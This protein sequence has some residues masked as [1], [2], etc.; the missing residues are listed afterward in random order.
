MVDTD[1]LQEAYLS[2]TCIDE[3]NSEIVDDLP[4]ADEVNCETEST[5]DVAEIDVPAAESEGVSSEY[6]SDYAEE[7]YEAYFDWVEAQ[8]EE[9]ADAHQETEAAD[10]PEA[11]FSDEYYEMYFDWVQQQ[12]E[13][14]LQAKL[15]TA[16][17]EA[18]S[19]VA[20]AKTVKRTFDIRQFASYCGSR[21]AS[22]ADSLNSLGRAIRTAA[23]DLDSQLR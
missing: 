7:Y 18:C 11:A 10:A 12:D 17:C 6:G 5:A 1:C 9:A 2:G 8:D 21:V 20:T 23:V 22:L 19:P 14:P 15:E 4:W 3:R 13:A 16:A